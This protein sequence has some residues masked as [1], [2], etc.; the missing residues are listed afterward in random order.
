MADIS[1]FP[2]DV[3]LLGAAATVGIY[4]ATARLT[5]L[6]WLFQNRDKLKDRPFVKRQIKCLTWFVFAAFG[7]GALAFLVIGGRALNWWL[8]GWAE[9]VLIC[10]WAVI[11]A[12][13]VGFHSWIESK[14]RNQIQAPEVPVG[15]QLRTLV[16][17][18]EA[19]SNACIAAGQQM[20][21]VA[22]AINKPVEVSSGGPKSGQH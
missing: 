4:S 10:W 3:A 14:H 12:C 7:A 6:G 13:F 17:Q 18:I 1:L 20:A 2:F 16:S 15:D 11:F 21:S 22:A 8:A 5:L 9:Y 19:A